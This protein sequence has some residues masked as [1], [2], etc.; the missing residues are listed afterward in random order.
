M[1]R[2]TANPR[3]GTRSELEQKQG[4]NQGRDIGVHHRRQGLAKPGIDRRLDRSTMVQLFA[5]PLED[6]HVGIDR[7]T[8][9]QHDAGDAG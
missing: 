6:Q 3:I 4:R 2:V 7:H 5:D 8:D 9:R 1:D